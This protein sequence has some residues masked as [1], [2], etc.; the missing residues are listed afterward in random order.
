ML[1]VSGGGH[2][3]ITD[4]ASLADQIF[5][6]TG[7]NLSIGTAFTVDA[8]NFHTGDETQA[9]TWNGGTGKEFVFN[10]ATGELWY[11]ANGTGADKVAL[12]HVSTGVVAADVHVF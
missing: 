4:F 3:S 11:S 8:A 5:V 2:D 10:G 1:K 9:A 6:N 7:D 12:A